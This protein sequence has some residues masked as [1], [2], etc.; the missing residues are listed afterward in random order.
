M[1]RQ[2][3]S[4]GG[5]ERVVHEAAHDV[6]SFIWVLSYC[7]MRN[8]CH[9]ASKTT[10]PKEIRNQCKALRVLF[11]KAFSQTTYRFISYERLYGSCVLTF[12]DVDDVKEITTKGMSGALIAL[13]HDLQGLI[14]LSASPFKSNPLTHDSLLAVVN[15]RLA[16]L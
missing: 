2:I 3:L 8:L 10:A 14:Y 9:R 6:E 15:Q 12:P 7:V 13:F 1:A 5:A 16:S 11:R 4:Q